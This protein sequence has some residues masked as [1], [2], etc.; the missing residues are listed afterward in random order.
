MKPGNI[1]QITVYNIRSTEFLASYLKEHDL[2]AHART[3]IQNQIKLFSQKCVVI[4]KCFW[5]ARLG[6]VNGKKLVL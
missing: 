3:D 1:D 6:N 5:K 2:L 4:T